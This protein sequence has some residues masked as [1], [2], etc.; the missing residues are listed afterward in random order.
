MSA[1]RPGIVALAKERGW[2][3]GERQRRMKYHIYHVIN[4]EFFNTT[5]RFKANFQDIE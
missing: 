4:Y 3:E 5:F 2:S 1:T